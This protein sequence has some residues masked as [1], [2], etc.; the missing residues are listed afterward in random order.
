MF[1][2]FLKKASDD[3]EDQ[4]IRRSGRSRKNV[5]YTF[6]EFEEDITSAVENDKK[7]FKGEEVNGEDQGL[8]YSKP[9]YETGRLLGTGQRNTRRSRRLMDLDYE[10][11]SES[12]TSGYECEGNSDEESQQSSTWHGNLRRKRR[13]INEDDEDDGSNH[14]VGNE[15][16]K[17]LKVTETAQEGECDNVTEGDGSVAKAGESVVDKK[18]DSEERT[19][20]KPDGKEEKTLE[21]NKHVTSEKAASLEKESKAVVTTTTTSPPSQ[22]APPLGN[23][24]QPHSRI[25]TVAPVA[26]NPPVANVKNYRTPPDYPPEG[27]FPHPPNFDI[28]KAQLPT[29]QAPNYLTPNFEASNVAASNIPGNN[30]T[31]AGNLHSNSAPGVLHGGP[32]FPGAQQVPNVRTN[33]GGP[34]LAGPTAG[35]PSF[36][37]TNFNFPKTNFGGQGGT[38]FG[39]SFVGGMNNFG[40]GVGANFGGTSNFGRNNATVSGMGDFS[41]MKSPPH[42]QSV[43]GSI[44][45]GQN[46]FNNM[47]SYQQFPQ[48]SGT[49]QVAI[50][51]PVK[52]QTLPPPYPSGT[53]FVGNRQY[54][55]YNQQISAN[56]NIQSNYI[57]PQQSGNFPDANFFPAPPQQ[58]P[59]PYTASSSQNANFYANTSQE[60]GSLSGNQW[61]YPE[62]YGYY[63]AQGSTTGQSF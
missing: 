2:H 37:G 47:Y 17:D 31:G 26:R 6:R 32:S 55:G 20:E 30:F 28:L 3:E 54:G 21:E 43:P 61:T 52:T 63:P 23:K 48:Q 10:S 7:R 38:N 58:P 11:D 56:S 5:D 33:F 53:Q 57:S 35:G 14:D 8:L 18:Q 34:A 42:T 22:N 45:G 51:A 62:G 25:A 50:S 19:E 12:R 41:G 4:G 36:P 1:F 49:S 27:V 9:A 60:G 44:W 39:G 24:I 15:N 13:I 46:D 59:P 16:T 29:K 40:P